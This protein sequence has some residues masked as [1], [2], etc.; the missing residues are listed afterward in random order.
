MASCSAYLHSS[1][2]QLN[3]P[4]TLLVGFSSFSVAA[5]ALVAATF[6]AA[7]QGSTYKVPSA[8]GS[9]EWA[10]AY[11]KAKALA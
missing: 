9:G 1:S 10:A 5:T 6:V 4:K 11:K 7:K 2:S 3:R 8:D